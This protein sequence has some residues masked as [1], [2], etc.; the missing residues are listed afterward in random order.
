[1]KSDDYITEYCAT[2]DKV[3]ILISDLIVAEMWKKHVLPELM[4]FLI[5]NQTYR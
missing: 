5:D 2:F 1:M 4:D 3:R